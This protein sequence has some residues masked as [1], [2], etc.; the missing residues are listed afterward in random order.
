MSNRR[1]SQP[2]GSHFSH[3]TTSIATATKYANNT[4]I[5]NAEAATQLM[6]FSAVQ[7]GCSDANG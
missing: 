3:A 4:N 6:D 5:R 7:K 1:L 2:S